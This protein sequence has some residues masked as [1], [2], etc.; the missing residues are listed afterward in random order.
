MTPGTATV[1]TE[2]VVRVDAP[3][4][5]AAKRVRTETGVSHGHVSVSSVAVDYARQVFETFADKTVLVIGAGK[6]GRLTLT[7]LR[8]LGPRRIDV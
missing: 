2:T 6:M 5:R 8:A 3:A 4:L 7:S 1:A